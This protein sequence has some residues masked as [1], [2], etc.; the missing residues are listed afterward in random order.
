MPLEPTSFTFT[1]INFR[2][3]CVYM[4][5]QLC[6][7]IQLLFTDKY[8]SSF[9]AQAAHE[10]LMLVEQMALKL[11]DVTKPS[12]SLGAITGVL[13]HLVTNATRKPTH[14]LDHFVLIQII[15]VSLCVFVVP[16]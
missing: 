4:L 5:L 8:L 11:M 2:V 12:P 1:S 10:Q 7:R 9:Q 16:I 6:F 14:G 3:A 13:L 15:K